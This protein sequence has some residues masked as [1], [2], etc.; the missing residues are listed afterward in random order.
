MQGRSRHLELIDAQV[1]EPRP[2]PHDLLLQVKALAV[3]PVDTKVRAGIDPG[4]AARI[5]G[6]DPAGVVVSCGEA[7]NRF[8]PGDAV[9]V[10][11]D[12][13]STLTQTLS[14][15]HAANVSAAQALLAGGHTI[16][17]IALEGWPQR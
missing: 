3:N 17:R 15:I 2:G 9:I 6:W 16:G 14:P 1:A 8:R 11:G 7:V 12:L 10:A 13:R 4:G 5:L